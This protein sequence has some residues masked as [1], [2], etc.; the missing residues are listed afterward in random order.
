MDPVSTATGQARATAID[1]YSAG[2]YEE[3]L[4][5][6]TAALAPDLEQA[7]LHYVRGVILESL[8]RRAEAEA[9]YRT[10]LAGEPTHAGAW[11]NL[12][13]LLDQRGEIDAAAACYDR[14]LQSDPDNAL[15]LANLGELFHRKDDLTT[16]RALLEAALARNPALAVAS[17]N[18]GRV[19]LAEH[20]LDEARRWFGEAVRQA[21]NDRSSGAFDSRFAD[22]WL[23]ATL[24]S[25]EVTAEESLALHSA[26]GDD[27]L[28]RSGGPGRPGPIP[29]R[30]LRPDEALVVGLLSGDFNAHPASRFLEPLFAHHDPSQMRL[31]AYHTLAE[32][33]AV[34]ERLRPRAD[35]WHTVAGWGCDQVVR[36]IEA[37][38]ID[39]LID[40][41]GHT[42][43]AR[44]DVLSSKPAAL[45]GEWLGYLHPSGLPTIDFRIADPLMEV[46]GQSARNALFL[47]SGIWCYAPY[48]DAPPIAEDPERGQAGRPIRFGSF[49]NPMKINDQ[50]LACWARLLVEEPESTLTLGGF[51]HPEARAAAA[52]RL[53]D[54]GVAA[55]RL[56]FLPKL[57]VAEYLAEV[58]RCDLALDPFPYGGGTTSFDCLW[59]GTPIVTREESRAC[60]R[61]TAAILRRLGL[62]GLVAPDLDTYIHIARLFARQPGSLTGGR[63]ALR[64]RLG[65]SPLTDGPS[66]CRSFEKALRIRW[67]Q[68]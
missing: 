7:A 4:A 14:V 30:S 68:P 36:R 51:N 1:L 54:L 65:Q 62:D 16:A 29:R 34:T 9:A 10:T 19:C 27:Y 24:C 13:R 38:G 35:G 11:I 45:Q 49:N 18:L 64:N 40:L 33:D 25:P 58:G 17:F 23:L 37:D 63:V 44:F 39:I 48:P 66:F 53:T 59:M 12:G 52:A 22:A 15:A 20:R 60:G 31:V 43:G 57:P 42:R 26:W 67:Q 5:V 55:P 47:P 46:S 8:G 28:R 2:R 3:A 41:S 50:V 32:E 61:G 21:G 6:V 56:R